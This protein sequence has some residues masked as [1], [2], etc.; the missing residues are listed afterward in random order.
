MIIQPDMWPQIVFS[1]EKKLNLDVCAITGVTDPPPFCRRTVCLAGRRMS[2]RISA[3]LVRDR[4]HP[5]GLHGRSAHKKP[6]LSPNDHWLRVLHAKR[7]GRMTAGFWSR[8]LFCDKACVGLHGTSGLV[9]VWRRPHEA[10]SLKCV[11]P[12]PEW[13]DIAQRLCPDKT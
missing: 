6:Y 13:L 11:V 4:I 10:F 8:V 3:D 1:D 5:A 2:R 12:T 9:S 7:F